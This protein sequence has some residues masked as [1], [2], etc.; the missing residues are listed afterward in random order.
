MAENRNKKYYNVIIVGA[1]P[2]GISTALSLLKNGINDILIIEKYTFPRYKC[3][4]G[5]ITNKTL[6]AYKKF[7][8]NV[9][10]CHYS[11]IKDFNIFYKLKNRLKIN[12]KFLYTNEKIDRVELDYEFFKLAKHKNVEILENT[13]ITSH[14]MH[15][16]NL[17]L[18]NKIEI[19]YN[20]LVFADGTIG[21]GSRYQ[22]KKKC[23]RKIHERIGKKK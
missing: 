11:L 23:N 8:L 7:G 13:T 6:A 12:N 18:S 19:A 9:N 22:K 20:Y 21:Y 4:A 10:D 15:A 14:N 17:T 3:C 16:N 2:A 5:Y 1:G